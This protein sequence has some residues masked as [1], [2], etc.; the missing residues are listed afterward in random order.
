M[1]CYRGPGGFRASTRGQ[2][3]SEQEH[4]AESTAYSTATE[5]QEGSGGKPAEA[6]HSCLILRIRCQLSALRSPLFALRLSLYASRSP[7]LALRFS[8]FFSTSQP[9]TSCHASLT[10]SYT[11]PR[12]HPPVELSHVSTM[13]AVTMTF[14]QEK[15][16]EVSNTAVTQIVKAALDNGEAVRSSTESKRSLSMTLR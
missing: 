9:L 11:V 13:A 10:T 2:E 3:G 6:T 15:L 7:L 16:A 5:G 14:T 1:Y 8:L 4:G 12:V